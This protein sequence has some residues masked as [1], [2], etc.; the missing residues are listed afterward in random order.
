MLQLSTRFVQ[1]FAERQCDQFQLPGKALEFRRRQECEQ[2]VLVV[3][4][5]R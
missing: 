4:V 5:E 2:V 1:H 3:T